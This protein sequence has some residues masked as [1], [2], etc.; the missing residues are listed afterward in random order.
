M[1][2]MKQEPTFTLM[3]QI[4][5]QIH[6]ILIQMVM[7]FVTDQIQFQEF[8]L[9]G[10]MQTLM[11][12]Q[13]QL[14]C[15]P[16][17]EQILESLDPEFQHQEVHMRY[18]QV[19]QIVQYQTPIQVKL[20]ECLQKHQTILLLQCGLIIQMAYHSLGISLQRFQKTLM[21]MDYLMNY[22]MITTQVTQI[23]QV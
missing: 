23:H 19:Y 1:T 8:V 12:F 20:Q 2:S 18:L 21:E 7:V 15:S 17:M 5:V 9:K 13:I 10:Q 16:L 22:Q 6:L 3:N 14:I 11:I 4:L